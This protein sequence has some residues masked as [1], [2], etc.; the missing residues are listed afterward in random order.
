MVDLINM[1]GTLMMSAKLAILDLLKI[2][3]FEIMIIFVPDVNNEVLSRDSNYIA[4]FG[5]SSNSVK[6]VII[7][8]VF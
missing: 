4:M 5:N 7:I 8:L 3:I 2:K 1:V 6:E